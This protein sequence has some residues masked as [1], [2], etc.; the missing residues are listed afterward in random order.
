[1]NQ[2][3]VYS[4][5]TRYKTKQQENIIHIKALETRYTLIACYLVDKHWLSEL[6]FLEGPEVWH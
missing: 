6:K 5:K 1:M 4:E 2:F 3:D